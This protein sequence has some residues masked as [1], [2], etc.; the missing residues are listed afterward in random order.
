MLRLI[1]IVIVLAAA[2]ALPF[3]FFGDRLDA[4]LTIDGA[5]EWMRGFAGWAWVAGIALI[6]SDVVLPVPSTA[7]MAALGIIYGP[8]LG[9]LISAA[10]SMTAGMLG[11]GLC[12]AIGPGVATRLAGQDG[13]NAAQA[14]FDRWGLWLI[15]FSRWLPVLPETVAFLAG[16]IRVPVRRFSFAL[17]VGCVPLGF[18]FASAGHLGQDTPVL[19]MFLCAAAPV[20][21]FSLG[22]AIFRN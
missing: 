8:V 18:L 3:V 20:I 19:I 9:G 14:L 7:V 17:A 1:L 5:T 16:L 15:A 12:R 6:A 22:R 2:V 13:M 21:L 10:G 4:V 11:Y